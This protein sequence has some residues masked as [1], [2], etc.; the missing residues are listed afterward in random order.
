MKRIPI[1]IF[2]TLVATL[3]MGQSNKDSINVDHYKTKEFDCAIFPSSSQLGFGN[4]IRFTPT[5][6][7]IIKAELKLKTQLKKLNKKKLN[8]S[9]TP[10]IDKNL[11]KY[12]RQ[13]FGYIDNNGNKILFI[14]CLWLEDN[15]INYSK[16][17]KRNIEIHDGGSY[18]WNIKFNLNSGKLF[19]FYVNGYA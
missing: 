13:Y 6:E 4:V 17:F 1:I 16:L 8:Q 9:S 7:E 12:F 2:L 14:N 11:S 18:Y 3:L 15:F 19:D 10:I 5:R